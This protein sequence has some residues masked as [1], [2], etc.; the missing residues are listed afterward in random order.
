MMSP[1]LVA[2]GRDGR[3]RLTSREMLAVELAL[4][5]SADALAERRGHGVS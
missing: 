5:R 3:E 1:D 2:L 4:E